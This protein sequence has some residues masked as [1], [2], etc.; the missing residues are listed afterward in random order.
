M[1]FYPGSLRRTLV[2]VNGVSEFETNEK[3]QTEILT[4]LNKLIKETQQ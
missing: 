4:E 3:F 1:E 2:S